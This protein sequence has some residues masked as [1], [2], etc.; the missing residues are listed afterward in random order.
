MWAAKGKLYLKCGCGLFAFALYVPP[1]VSDH[2]VT[3]GWVGLESVFKVSLNLICGGNVWNGKWIDD[4][5]SNNRKFCRHS[6][7]VD[8]PT[9]S[10]KL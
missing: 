10:Y 3:G 6:C 8:L 9:A 7:Y 5:K 1:P 2:H 4:L